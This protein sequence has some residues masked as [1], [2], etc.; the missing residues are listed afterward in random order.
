MDHI[1]RDKLVQLLAGNLPEEE[2]RSIEQ[3]LSGCAA[4]EET[5][6]IIVRGYLKGVALT[7]EAIKSAEP[8]PDAKPV[9]IEKINKELVCTLCGNHL[10]YSRSILLNT[11][12]LTYFLLDWLNRSAKCYECSQCGYIH[13]FR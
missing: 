7:D 9:W 2:S 4:C 8:V 1:D 10:F 6:R 12:F 11:R 3:H 5:Y 13:W